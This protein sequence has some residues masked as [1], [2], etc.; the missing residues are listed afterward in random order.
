MTGPEF[1]HSIRPDG[2]GG[3][4][5]AYA[6]Q[7]ST[8][9]V[10]RLA[11]EGMPDPAWTT[12]SISGL[13]VVPSI[14]E[15]GTCIAP[16]PDGTVWLFSDHALEGVLYYRLTAGTGGSPPTDGGN[17]QQTQIASVSV[18]SADGRTILLSWGATPD[19]ILPAVLDAEGVLQDPP[20]AAILTTG[21]GTYNSLPAP[22]A[23]ADGLGGAVL[24][25]QKFSTTE[26]AGVPSGDDLFAVRVL[27][28]GSAAWLP[29]VRT[30][31]NANGG[32]NDVSVCPDGAGG[33][34]FAW[35]DG[36]TPGNR[37]D[38]YVQHILADGTFAPGFVFGGRDL[39]AT[40]SDSFQPRLAEDGAGGCW[41]VWTDDRTSNRDIHF[42]HLNAAGVPVAGFPPGGR[43][44]C[45]APGEQIEPAVSADGTGGI[46]LVWKDPRDGESDL[47]GQHIFH[48]G[49]VMAGWEPDGK[50]LCTNA[51]EPEA[52][53]LAT[54][55]SGHAI[56]VWVDRRSG[57]PQIYSLA[58]PPDG[59]VTEVPP[60]AQARLSL[61]PVRSPA[62]GAIELDLSASDAG[63]VSVT[64]LDV[65]GRR[66][67]ELRR[68]GPLAAA[69]VR[70]TRGLPA[71]L[72]LVTASQRGRHVTAKV[73]TLR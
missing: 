10:T 53:A 6:R 51:F 13:N 28:D 30:L 14:P 2:M 60:S 16:R 5:V 41:I 24:A 61:A 25:F 27:S 34:W 38:V 17:S 9:H 37:R 70:F 11:P 21:S 31:S 40:T 54:P 18:P 66:L 64:L 32:Q 55:S 65:S 26:W 48:T 36:R 47:Y 22:I 19:E 52:P 71:G 4:Y 45:A 50:P 7:Q 63:E 46:F 49:D 8:R 73:A 58:F 39:A 15:Y 1:Q 23:I 33:A 56:A 72:Y 69:R 29:P 20:P 43:S 35:S 62:R 57:F 42:T 68:S 3:A 67:E 44:L 12:F 59:D